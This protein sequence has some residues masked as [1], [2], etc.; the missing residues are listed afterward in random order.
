MNKL[1]D[2]SR[3]PDIEVCIDCGE[4]QALP[5]FVRQPKDAN[6]AKRL[7]GRWPSVELTPSSEDAYGIYKCSVCGSVFLHPS[8][9][10]ESRAC[11]QTRRYYDGYYPNNIHIGGHPNN[12]E[13]RFPKL[14]VRMEKARASQL[15]RLARRYADKLSK[16]PA[17]CD[18][19]C[20]TG[21]FVRG[22]L[23]IGIDAYGVE[24]SPHALRAMERCGVER[25]YHGPF[26][27]SDFGGRK[28]DI[29][30]LFQTAEHVID[31]GPLLRAMRE[32]LTPD[33]III[34]NCPNDVSGY[35]PLFWRRYWWLVPPMHVR[36]FNSQTLDM[37][38]RKNGLKALGFETTGSFG[39]DVFMVLDWGARK[40]HIGMNPSGKLFKIF[41][42]I[43]IRGFIPVDWLIRKTTGHSELIA[44]A[45]R[46][47]E[48]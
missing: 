24:I 37:L 9:Y 46:A 44:V 3:L 28:F 29:I 18:I 34:L 2:N 42:Q 30:T 15:L 19:G 10:E 11:Y 22:C 25:I 31:M 4:M 36:F 47:D 45:T 7:P 48:M 14:K 40:I 5:T 20:A 41:R 23:D 12:E 8:H 27:N 6:I 38:F 13:H 1:A 35:R 17:L 39:G 16:E 43:F 21:W 26:E 33:G 32:R